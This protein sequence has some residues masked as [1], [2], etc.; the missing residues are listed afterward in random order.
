MVD[1]GLRARNTEYK[2]KLHEVM[3][4]R[5]VWYVVTYFLLLLYLTVLHV[6]FNW[7]IKTY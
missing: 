7:N 3:T 1:G 2:Q 4:Y 6:L 5:V